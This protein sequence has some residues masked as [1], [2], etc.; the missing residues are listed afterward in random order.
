MDHAVYLN[1]TDV[2]IVLNHMKI[3][4]QPPPGIEPGPSTFR[5]VV[6][7]LNRLYIYI[8]TP[9][10]SGSIPGGGSTIFI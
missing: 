5:A 9:S 7:P 2:S 1:K 3:V 8:N 4:D 6:Q 10:C